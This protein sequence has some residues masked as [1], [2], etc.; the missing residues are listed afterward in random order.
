MEKVID[1]A[2]CRRYRVFYPKGW[3]KAFMAQLNK[4]LWT[5]V[6]RIPGICYGD[7]RSRPR[8]ASPR[9]ED[10]SMIFVSLRGFIGGGIGGGF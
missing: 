3:R 2:E 4:A 9:F 6:R 7:S 10:G 1:R 5:G 8:G